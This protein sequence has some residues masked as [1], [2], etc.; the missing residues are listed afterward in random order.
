MALFRFLKTPDPS[1]Y[2]YKPRFWDPEK[3]KLER[4]AAELARRKAQG[5]ADDV[6]GRLSGSFRNGRNKGADAKLIRRDAK[7]R[8]NYT[9]LAIIIVLVLLSYLLVNVNL[10]TI[11]EYVE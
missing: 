9:L 8:S 3:E 6:K 11:L 4:R 10:H 5:T 1:Q 2:D 7:R